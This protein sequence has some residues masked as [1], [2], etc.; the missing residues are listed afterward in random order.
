MSYN[1]KQFHLINL[2]Y[3]QD[4]AEMVSEPE[5][6]KYIT[7]IKAYKKRMADVVRERATDPEDSEV[8]SRA[9]SINLDELPERGL[10][11]KYRGKDIQKKRELH[12]DLDPE[13]IEELKNKNKI[14]M[15][16]KLYKINLNEQRVSPK[17]FVTGKVGYEIMTQI[18]N[19]KQIKGCIKIE[20]IKAS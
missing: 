2:K 19:E 5:I 9:S 3:E 13:E 1:Q 4:E 15:D 8:I 20:E 17:K 14:K 7:D 18:G 10:L 16:P 11:S 12:K 6:Y